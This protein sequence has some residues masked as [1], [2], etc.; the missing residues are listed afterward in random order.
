MKLSLSCF[1]PRA[2]A[3]LVF[4]SRLCCANA[5]LFLSLLL[6]L[7]PYSLSSSS[8][9]HSSPLRG[10]SSVSLSSLLFLPLFLSVL[11][12][13]FHRSRLS[14]T[15]SHSLPDRS[16]PA[17][18]S[19]SFVGTQI[20]SLFLPSFRERE[21]E[22]GGPSLRLPPNGFFF[23]SPGFYISLSFVS[24]DRVFHSKIERQR[25]CRARI[26]AAKTANSRSRPHARTRTRPAIVGRASGRERATGGPRVPPE[27]VPS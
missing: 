12:L 22:R 27:R 26:F 24:P 7:F 4:T 15:L 20:K 25:A 11:H 21:R 9:F 8:S 13:L 1:G 14:L 19:V 23:P 17:L 6:S 2:L 3:S 10:I 16:S 18:S 5:Q